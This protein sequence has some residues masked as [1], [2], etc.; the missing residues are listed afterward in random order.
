M[1]I[2]VSKKLKRISDNEFRS[3]DNKIMAIIF[4]IHKE[5]GRFWNEKI[6]QNEHVFTTFQ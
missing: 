2:E 3:L 6:Y 5:L 4:S 1:P